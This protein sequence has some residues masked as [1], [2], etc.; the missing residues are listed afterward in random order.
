MARTHQE[1]LVNSL[2]D[3]IRLAAQKINQNI[4][5]EM[6]Y[7]LDRA[8]PSLRHLF[9]DAIEVYQKNSEDR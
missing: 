2:I 8:E 6:D 9:N 4:Y 1:Q 3:A 7:F 5:H